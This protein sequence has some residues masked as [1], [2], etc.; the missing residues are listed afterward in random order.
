MGREAY[1]LRLTPG[2]SGNLSIRSRRGLIISGSGVSLGF[3]DR[4]DYVEVADNDVSGERRASSELPM[5]A[6]IYRK[7]P[8]ARAIL[9]FHGPWIIQMGTRK[10]PHRWVPEPMPPEFSHL[11]PEGYIPRVPDMDPGSEELA[12]STAAAL[13]C[14][15]RGAIL[16]GHGGV[17]WGD[18]PRDALH[19]AEAMESAGRSDYLHRLMSVIEGRDVR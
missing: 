1:R 18:S 9:H 14:G 19:C 7:V 5:H 17:A 8:E 10:C 12:E 6:A 3:A 4:K 11:A 16:C 15:S 2:T 13:L